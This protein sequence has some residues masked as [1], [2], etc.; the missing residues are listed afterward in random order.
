[1]WEI[2]YIIYS[3]CQEKH[4]RHREEKLEE[5]HLVTGHAVLQYNTERRRIGESGWFSFNI[6]MYCDVCAIV[7]QILT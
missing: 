4:G 5:Q 7:R 1:M 6:N 3:V 2:L